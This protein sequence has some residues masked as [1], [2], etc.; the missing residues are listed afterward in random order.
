M[1]YKKTNPVRYDYDLEFVIVNNLIPELPDTRLVFFFWKLYDLIT[2]KFVY[3][4]AVQ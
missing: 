3:T 2:R 1:Y 4:R